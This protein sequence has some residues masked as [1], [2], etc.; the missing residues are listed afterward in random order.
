MLSIS[1]STPSLFFDIDGTLVSYEKHSIP[2]STIDG[3][4]QAKKNGCLIF[5]S[6]GRPVQFIDNLSSIKH[7]IDGY[8]AYNGAYCY[9]GNEQLF[10]KSVSQEALDWI[11]ND[12]SDKDYPVIFCGTKDIGVYNP[13][14]VVTDLFENALGLKNTNFPKPPL[15]I[16]KEQSILQFSPFVDSSREDEVMSHLKGCVY[17]RWHP[18]FIDVTVKGADK[19][20]GMNEVVAKLGLNKDLTYAFGDGGNDMTIIQQAHTGIAMGNA[21]EQLKKV[22]NY[23]T[24]DVDKDGIYLALKHFKLI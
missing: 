13:K 8:I 22:A 7:L 16:I 4:T 15:D 2:Q 3:I 20:T 6:T 12:A 14:P 24:E 5:I 19:G 1:A 10:R 17:G 9:M 21:C 23:I 11:I 18:A